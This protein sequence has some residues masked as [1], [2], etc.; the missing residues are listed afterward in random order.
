MT[1]LILEWTG[2]ELVASRFLQRRGEILF[3]GADSRS[4]ATETELTDALRELPPAGNDSRIALSLPL[5]R[6]FMREMGLPIRDRK[7]LREVLPLELRGETALETDELAFAGLP[8]AGG[9]VLALWGRK[10]ELAACISATAAAGVEPEVLSAAPLHWGELLPS[11]DHGTVALTDGSA[12][13]LFRDREPL[14][15]RALTEGEDCARTLALLEISK[16]IT[17]DRTCRLGASATAE[18]T[19]LPVEGSLAAA[20]GCDEG[21]AR[22]HGSAWALATA[23]ARGDA[24]DFRAGDLAWTK[25]KEKAL[26]RLR[27]PLALAAL[28]LL[29]LGADAGIR[30]LLV[31]RDLASLDASIGA[32]YREVFPGR[33]KGVDEAAEMRTEIRKLGASGGK[34]QVLETLNRLATA[35][36]DDILGLYEVEI[37]GGQV[38]LKGDARS[39]QAVN[40]FKNRLAAMLSPAD[41]GQITSKPDGTVTFTLRGTMKEGGQ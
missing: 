26:R 10:Q 22:R 18:G 5:A 29:L 13:A 39:T 21:A 7:K 19:P 15:F 8:L 20:F 38:R 12:L 34:S 28:L 35:K 9:A 2:A 1:Y 41:V 31:K 25:G 11:G 40:D 32:I 3:Q 4:A 17:V 24:V 36:G 27:L 23:M 37:D 16:G 33:K 14:F 6:L 30:Y